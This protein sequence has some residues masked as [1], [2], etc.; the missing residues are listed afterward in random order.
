MGVWLKS[1]KFNLMRRDGEGPGAEMKCVGP[2]APVFFK[3]LKAEDFVDS[4]D[5][6]VVHQ[7]DVAAEK[8][9]VKRGRGRPRKHPVVE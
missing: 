6:L 9:P 2:A 7:A 1:R 5:Y 8:P 4:R 3:N